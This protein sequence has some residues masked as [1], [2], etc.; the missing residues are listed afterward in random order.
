MSM[1][2]S[3]FGADSP[4]VKLTNGTLFNVSWFAVVTTASVL[5]APLVVVLHIAIHYALVG[6]RRREL[7]LI[8]AVTALGLVIDQI[9]FRTGV[10][11]L[12][13]VLSA[14]PLW[15]TC[16]WPL[17]ATTLMHA[18]S[19]LQQRHVLAV[20]MGAVGGG[21]SYLAG[22]RLSIVDFADPFWGP[23]ILAS[24]WAVLMPSLLFLAAR[25]EHSGGEFDD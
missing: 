8:G 6:F 5:V 25:L 21:L 18:F 13:G 7:V 19:V 1:L 24:L 9:L 16:L 10:F 20:V 2:G 11:T 14:P 22:T 4:Y 12:D 15:L 23:I 3:K 17:L